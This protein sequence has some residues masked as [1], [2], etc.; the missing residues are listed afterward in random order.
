MRLEEQPKISFRLSPED[1]VKFGVIDKAGPTGVVTPKMSKGMG[2][3]VKLTC[4]ANN[5]GDYKV[6]VYKVTDLEKLER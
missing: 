2:W 1:A 3:K 4:N 6:P 5:L